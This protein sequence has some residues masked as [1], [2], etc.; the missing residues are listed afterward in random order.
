MYPA[1]CWNLKGPCPCHHQH[2]STC[3]SDL[4][5]EPCL[6]ISSL[7]LY[8]C[9]H[10]CLP[11]HP[12]LGNI[13]KRHTQKSKIES[14]VCELLGSSYHLCWFCVSKKNEK[15][16]IVHN[17]Q[18][19]NAIMIRN[20]GVSQNVEPYAE[21]CAEWVIYTIGDSHVSYDHMPLAE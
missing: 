13:F 14:G 17:L 4:M 15:F 2:C 21:H 19:L 10:S 6:F 12:W 16:C 9:W 3:S 8:W 7:T 18:P 1:S 5:S 11:V 20:V